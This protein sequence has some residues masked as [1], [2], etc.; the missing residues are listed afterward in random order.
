VLTTGCLFHTS[1][2]VFIQQTVFTGVATIWKWGQEGVLGAMPQ[3]PDTISTNSSW[4]C[5]F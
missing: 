3:K 1:V 5:I 4:E 2:D